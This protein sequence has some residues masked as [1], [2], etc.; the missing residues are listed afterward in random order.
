MFDFNT[1]AQLLKALYKAKS[2]KQIRL[3]HAEADIEMRQAAL[4]P[5]GGWLAEQAKATVD[6]RKQACATCYAT[7]DILKGI[8]LLVSELR[9]TLADLEA[10]IDGAEA[11]RKGGEW[12][13][14][15]RYT[16]VLDRRLEQPPALEAAA[17]SEAAPYYDDVSAN[18]EPVTTA[19][20]ETDDSEFPF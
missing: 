13:E 8:N 20:T 1:N 11:E 18:D 16:T 7:D 12:S 14:K 3:R 17:P 6:Q 10:Q 2:E 9:D 4:V 19:V 15:Q 5:P